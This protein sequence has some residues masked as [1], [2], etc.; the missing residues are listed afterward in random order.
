MNNSS[1]STNAESFVSTENILESLSKCMF[2]NEAAKNKTNRNFL[3]EML[4]S[5]K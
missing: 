1:N 2:I 5:K 4:S 3:R